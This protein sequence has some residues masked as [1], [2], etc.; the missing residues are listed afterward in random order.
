M[1]ISHKSHVDGLGFSAQ[2]LFSPL[3]LVGRIP[4]SANAE[5]TV[6]NSRRI[7]HEILEGQDDRLMIIVGPCSIHDDKAALQYAE[8]LKGIRDTISEKIFLVMRAYFEKPRTTVGW[9]GFINDPDLDETFDIPSGLERSRELLLKINELGIPVASEFL[10]PVVPHYIEDLVSWVAIGART[11]ESQTHRQM[12][13]AIGIP[14]GF[15]NGTDGTFQTAVDAIG[16][17]KQEHSY[18]GTGPDGHVCVLRTDGNP[19]GH[20]VLRG[21]KNGPNYD[22]SSVNEALE[23]LGKANLNKRLVIDCSHANSNKDHN[24]QPIV[25]ED[26]ITQII[27]G[28]EG[29]AGVMLESHINPGNQ[30]LTS[31]ISKLEFGVSI[32]DACVGWDKTKEI[33][34]WA[35][36]QL[37]S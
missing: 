16:A 32:T 10:D 25:F 27:N 28:N 15:K 33:L 12:A 6:E 35:S 30:S 17:S 23:L 29:I 21:G 20:M 8:M 9:K 11:T 4:R 5:K 3:E 18:V 34:E 7:I 22:S 36:D 19:D 2:R 14:V 13:S 37:K 1:D 24:R 31:D 26:V